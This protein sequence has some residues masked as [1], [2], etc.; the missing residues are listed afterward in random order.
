MTKSI[1]GNV[2]IY[3]TFQLLTARTDKNVC[4]MG[5]NAWQTMGTEVIELQNAKITWTLAWFV[6][7]ENHA[8]TA[9]TVINMRCDFVRYVQILSQLRTYVVCE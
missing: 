9:G 5:V 3:M 6:S 8:L 7:L 1:A 2:S 4:M